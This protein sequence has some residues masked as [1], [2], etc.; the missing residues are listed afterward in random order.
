MFWLTYTRREMTMD[1]VDVRIAIV[2]PD[3]SCSAPLFCASFSKLRLEKSK[4]SH[5]SERICRKNS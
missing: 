1:R 4:M 3:C 5:T 2:R